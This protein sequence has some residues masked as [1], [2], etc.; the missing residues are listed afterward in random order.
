MKT[1]EELRTFKK[2]DETLRQHYKH[3]QESSN[4]IQS[5]RRS[6]K[7]QNIDEKQ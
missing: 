3:L 2:I 1:H 5:Q 4:Q 7:S 6:W